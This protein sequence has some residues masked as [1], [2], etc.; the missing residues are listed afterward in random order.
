[1]PER[2]IKMN[3]FFYG[4]LLITFLSAK[5]CK[6]GEFNRDSYISFEQSRLVEGLFTM[7]VVLTH[8]R[9]DFALNTALDKQYFAFQSHIKQ[10]VVAMFLFYSGFGVMNNIMTK[11]KDYVGRKLPQRFVRLFLQFAIAVAIF[12]VFRAALGYTYSFRMYA[13]SFL[14][15]ESIGNSNWFI[16]CSLWMYVFAIAAYFIA[17]LI[18]GRRPTVRNVL[19]LV[20]FTAL[21]VGYVK[22]MMATKGQGIHMKNYWWYDTALVFAFGAWYR[23]LKEKVDRIVMH[24]DLTYFITVAIVALVYVLAWLNKES[25]FLIYELWVM[26]FTFG[27]VLLT[28]KISLGSSLLAFA[29]SHVFSIY[30][31]QRI[32]LQVLAKIG[33]VKTHPYVGLV[34]VIAATVLIAVPFDALLKRILPFGSKKSLPGKNATVQ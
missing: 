5:Y 7:L 15:W 34:I 31:L 8:F 29:G 12:A 33:L 14:G 18:S 19:F 2:V 1:M 32:P 30:M 11:G 24:S 21:S 22:V 16:F 28:M 3:T 10:C 26:C 20:L 6:K 4:L 17:N 23:F 25:S 13:L 27:V 9:N